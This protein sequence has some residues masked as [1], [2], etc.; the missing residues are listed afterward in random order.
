MLA[1]QHYSMLCFLIYC[2]KI[3][4][5][6]HLSAFKLHNHSQALQL[7]TQTKIFAINRCDKG[8]S[9]EMILTTKGVDKCETILV[10]IM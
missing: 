2:L 7:Y 9:R 1:I 4:T 5:K 10:E 8:C 3:F 6:C